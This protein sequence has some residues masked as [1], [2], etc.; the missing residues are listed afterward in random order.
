MDISTFWS[1]DITSN[2]SKNIK[3]YIKRK[4]KLTDFAVNYINNILI[5][6]K[7]FEEHINHLIKLLDAIAKK[8]F[9]LKL[10][11]CNF[12]S[13]C[14]KYLGHIIENNTIRSVKDNLKSIKDFPEP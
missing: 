1:Q 5:F 6:S 2:F 13:S 3:Q 14:A 8:R 7:N 10:T 12:A 9:R 11:K 4:Y